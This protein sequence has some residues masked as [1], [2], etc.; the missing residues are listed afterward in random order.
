MMRDNALAAS[1]LLN[2]KVGD[3]SVRPY[4]PEGLWKMNFDAYV[5]DSGDKLYRRSFYTIW[6]RT[7]PNPTLATFDQPER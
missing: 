4:Q 6:R 7:I 5:Q 2:R 3:E 1:G